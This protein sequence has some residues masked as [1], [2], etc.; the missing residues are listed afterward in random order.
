[1]DSEFT[2][3]NIGLDEYTDVINQIE[4]IDKKVN[5]ENRRINDK[6]A[7]KEIR[8]LIHLLEFRNS[9]V[10][11][12]K[13]EKSKVENQT[14]KDFSPYSKFYIATTKTDQYECAIVDDLPSMFFISSIDGSRQLRDA[15][16]FGNAYKHSL[17]IMLDKKWYKDRMQDLLDT[18]NES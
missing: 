16:Y 8:L 5:D 6:E 17:Q 11:V 1:M 10:S 14:I 9:K 7:K 3:A 15:H 13:V 18:F 12:E 2:S 4:E